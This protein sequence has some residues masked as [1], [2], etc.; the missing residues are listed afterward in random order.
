MSALALRGKPRNEPTAIGHGSRWLDG[1]G[2]PG[3]AVPWIIARSR[4]GNFP[5][6]TVRVGSSPVWLGLADQV[7]RTPREGRA[8]QAEMSGPA[9]CNAAIS[10]KPGASIA[11]LSLFGNPEKAIR[12][13]Q[14]NRKTPP[15]SI[16]EADGT[17]LG[18]LEGALPLPSNTCAG[19]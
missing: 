8:V 9:S 17:D 13:I 16:F 14:P 4:D 18:P 3:R 11:P 19:S 5:F 10:L 15:Q 12:I 6:P 7:S 2:G 1:L